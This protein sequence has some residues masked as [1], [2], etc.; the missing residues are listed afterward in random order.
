VTTEDQR[1]S[2][3][4]SIRGPARAKGRAGGGGGWRDERDEDALAGSHWRGQAYTFHIIVEAGIDAVQ[5]NAG[6]LTGIAS[7]NDDGL[8]AV[9][10]PYAYEAHGR[11]SRATLRNGAYADYLYDRG[12]RLTRLA[13]YHSVFNDGQGT[14][15]RLTTAFDCTYDANSNIT[16]IVQDFNGAE[17]ARSRCAPNP[18]RSL[19]PFDNPA[20]L[21]HSDRSG[22]RS[23]GSEEP[24]KA[25]RGVGCG[26]V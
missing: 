6:R 16:D 21:W 18:L 10:T 19:F 3:R 15:R 1:S 7:S 9:S 14:T 13:N 17:V 12:G 11:L 8:T 22:M 2:P 26:P 24:R 23:S 5:S 20:G 25:S 4:D